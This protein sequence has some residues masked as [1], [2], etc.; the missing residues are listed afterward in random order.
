MRSQF[1]RSGAGILAYERKFSLLR[2][3]PFFLWD[4]FSNLFDGYQ[5]SFSDVDQPGRVADHLR[6]SSVMAK[7]ACSYS[8][9]LPCGFITIAGTNVCFNCERKGL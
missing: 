4:P 5:S 3:V 6:T 9:T 2:N 7:K 1:G 8:F